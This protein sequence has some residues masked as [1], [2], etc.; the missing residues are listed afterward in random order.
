MDVHARGRGLPPLGRALLLLEAALP[1]ST[2]ERLAALPVGRRDDRILELRARTLGPLIQSETRCPAC[3]ERLE[4]DL[5]SDELRALADDGASGASEPLSVEH[6]GWGALVRLPTSRD[7][8][9]VLETGGSEREL[10]ALCLIETSRDGAPV[11]ADD[12]PV[13]LR[14]AVQAAMAEA[15]PL[16]D[17]QLD[18][19]CPACGHAWQAPFDPTSFFWG[20]IEA[21][22]PRLLREV[23][24]LAAAYGWSERAI[25]SMDT[26]RR[27]Q[28][29]RLVGA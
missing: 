23:H 25:L 28:Y 10:L 27:G 3:G 14:E 5:R 17:V 20:E 8:L 21:W 24:M 1:E 7:L 9:S 6:D 2:A 26:W 16:A 22:I 12:L 19:S 4:F 13:P 11:E 15:D 29:L 18:L